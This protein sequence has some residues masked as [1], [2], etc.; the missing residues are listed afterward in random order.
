MNISNY[1]CNL[2]SFDQERDSRI[3]SRKNNNKGCEINFLNWLNEWPDKKVVSKGINYFKV[4]KNI[5]YSHSKLNTNSYLAHVLRVTE[6]A[7]N[8][9]PDI[10]NNS[11]G[12]SLIHNIF[13]VS[14]YTKNDLLNYFDTA[15]I[16]I[17]EIL[18][19]D[20]NKEHMH[21]YLLGYYDNIKF[22]E[23]ALVVKLADKIDNIFTLC[24]NNDSD[25]R[26]RY[27]SVVEVY[28]LPLIKMKVPH[29]YNYLKD[30]IADSRQVG[31]IGQ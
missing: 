26:E 22:E 18:T 10:S 14:K 9:R 28:L 5:K 15:T 2:R 30:L 6:I 23:S 17:V 8:I 31:F 20:R 25:K 13:E 12:V 4:V 27:L 21:D 11:I 7:M 19:I 1:E 3:L 24:L 16:E 29:F